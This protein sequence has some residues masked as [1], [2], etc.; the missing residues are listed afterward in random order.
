MPGATL[1]APV[2]AMSTFSFATHEHRLSLAE[3]LGLLVA[4]GWIRKADADALLE[5]Y[6]GQ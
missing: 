4:D 5:H 3:I 6:Y 1:R 2:P